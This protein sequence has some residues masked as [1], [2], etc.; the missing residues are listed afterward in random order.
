V[1]ECN[2]EGAEGWDREDGG[3]EAST[4]GSAVV[5]VYVEVVVAGAFSTERDGSKG[6]S[7]CV[8]DEVVVT[9]VVVVAV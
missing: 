2:W 5:G 8:I 4:Y 3:S 1:V 9:V 6:V 7:S